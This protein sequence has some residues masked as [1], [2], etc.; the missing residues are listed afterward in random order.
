MTQEEYVQTQQQ[1]LL[2]LNWHKQ[3][4]HDHRPDSG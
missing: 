1:I 4:S 2:L 3:A